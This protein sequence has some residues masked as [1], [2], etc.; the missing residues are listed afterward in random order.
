MDSDSPLVY[1]G[2]GRAPSD[3]ARP[4]TA[5]GRR[6][7]WRIGGG[8]GES[9]A[10]REYVVGGPGGS[11]RPPGSPGAD[12][13]G[14]PRRPDGGSTGGYAAPRA[15]SCRGGR[16]RVAWASG[17]PINSGPGTVVPEDLDRE[18]IHGQGEGASPRGLH[19][20]GRHVRLF[21]PS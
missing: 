12:P 21:R 8:G 18:P 5:A 4:A 2:A 11:G 17:V 9:A 1:K 10:R 6:C 13:A 3:R 15:N 20:A 19:G 7:P 16:G 14:D